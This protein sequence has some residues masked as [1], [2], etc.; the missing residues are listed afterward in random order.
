M[1]FYFIK[2]II[3]RSQTFSVE[4]FKL[5]FICIIKIETYSG[6]NIGGKTDLLI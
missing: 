4:I 1:G 2:A 3:I 6:G 5:F